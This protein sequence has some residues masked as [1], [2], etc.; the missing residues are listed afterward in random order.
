MAYQKSLSISNQ[1]SLIQTLSTFITAN[2]W[3]EDLLDTTNEKATFHKGSCYVSFQWDNSDSIAMYQS[4][5]YAGAGANPW[6]HTDDSGNGVAS[7]SGPFTTERRIS[8][9]GNGSFTRTDFFLSTSPDVVYVVLEFSP[10][11]YRHFAFG[12]IAKIGDWTGGEF[13]AGHY[14]TTGGTSDDPAYSWHSVLADGITIQNS[15]VKVSATLH[16]EGLPNQGGSGKWGVIGGANITEG[17]DRGAVARVIIQGGCRASTYLTQFGWLPSNL[18]NAFVPLIPIPLW[19]VDETP[20]GNDEY[21]L[22]GFLSNVKHLNIGGFTEAQE[23][24]VGGGTWI[25]FPIVRK[26][27]D[28]DD[29]QQSWNGGLAYKKVP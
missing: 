7:T 27:Y 19:Y 20:V 26:K 24:T 9:I 2:G 18:V 17:T 21:Y 10:G 1:Q 25:I 4:L 6:A 8:G 14:W 16:C 15:A 28:L 13:V 3:T 11:I 5:G 23:I 22:L 12:N 29:T